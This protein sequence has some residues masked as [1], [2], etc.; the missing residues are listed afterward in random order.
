MA[1]T[2]NYK[3]N[4]I[5][6]YPGHIAKAEKN[7]KEQLKR[8][9]VVLEVR[10]A[11][12][13]L[14]THHPQIEEWVGSKTRLLVLN[15]LDMISPQV[16]SLWADWFKR[17]GEVAFFTNAQQGQGVTAVLKAAQAAGIEL[18]NRRRDRGMLP[19]PVRAVVIGF[20]NVG[21]SAL[22]NRL[23]GKRVVESAARPGVTRQLRWVRISDQL[24]LL[25]APGVIPLKLE[26]QEAA[27]KLAICDDIG[28]ASYDNQLVAAEL[29]NVLN[30]LQDV[31][32]NLLPE[33]PLQA[34]Y[35]L[36]S[37]PHTGEAYL[38]ALGEH[39]YKGDVERAARHLL[40]DYRKG[41]MGEIPLELPP[42]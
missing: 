2:Q 39:R 5:Q 3:L 4:V 17:Q 21:K 40:T 26:D 24:E 35:E 36:D 16:R 33:K 11:R 38:H 22:I 13:P 20:P 15:R 7:L 37:S 30:Y 14:A 1:L 41:F 23:L 31:A 42:N 6:W 18:N 29:V 9:D 12:I 32:T 19:R 28:E 10:D 8:V 25:D 34:R 27:L